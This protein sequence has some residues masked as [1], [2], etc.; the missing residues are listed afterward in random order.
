[1]NNRIDDAYVRSIEAIAFHPEHTP[2]NDWLEMEENDRDKRWVAGHKKFEVQYK[3]LLEEY[4]EN[5]EATDEEL[6]DSIVGCTAFLVAVDQSELFSYMLAVDENNHPL[7]RDTWTK[8][9]L[10]MVSGIAC[11]L[12]DNLNRLINR[13]KTSLLPFDSLEESRQALR[14]E[15]L[16]TVLSAKQKAKK[17]RLQEAERMR[18][19]TLNENFSKSRDR[20]GGWSVVSDERSV[21]APEAESSAELGAE[22]VPEG[23][24]ASDEDSAPLVAIAPAAATLKTATD[25]ERA[26]RIA[27][28][29][30]AF[31]KADAAAKAAALAVAEEEDKA[32]QEL[33][34]EMGDIDRKIAELQRIKDARAAELARYGMP[35]AGQKRGPEDDAAGPASKKRK[36]ADEDPKMTAFLADDQK[37]LVP[38]TGAGRVSKGGLFGRTANQSSKAVTPHASHGAVLR[39]RHGGTGTG[40]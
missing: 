21:G 35:L 33:E 10:D 23:Q 37:V 2:G 4:S 26:K 22:A 29:R 17:L 27:E 5:D 1:M 24:D 13:D 15:Y 18:G 40:R 32:R 3:Q 30:E 9:F 34:G 11:C 36:V 8:E 12:S 7:E 31:A 39:R 25:E 6:V 19:E 28:K 20:V 16:F 38:M 14:V